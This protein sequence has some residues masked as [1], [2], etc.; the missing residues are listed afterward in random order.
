MD[1]ALK[2]A[3]KQI[4]EEDSHVQPPACECSERMDSINEDPG[5]ALMLD[6][7][8]EQEKQV[9]IQRDQL[10]KDFSDKGYSP[11][12][13]GEPSEISEG[14]YEFEKRLYNLDVS[15]ASGVLKI[16]IP[17]LLPHRK[18]TSAAFFE[19]FR[20]LLRKYLDG[21]TEQYRALQSETINGAVLIVRH[22]YHAARLVKDNDNFELR[23]VINILNDLG[24][25]Y[26]DSGDYLSIFLTA[27]IE[28]VDYTELCLMSKDKFTKVVTNNVA[29]EEKHLYGSE[30]QQTE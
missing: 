3:L 14:L 24:Y 13:L 10:I 27:G 28:G 19:P 7:I 29:S 8:H 4:K 21:H 15:Y 11:F 9:V 17:A 23:T 16:H 6:L 18:Y 30:E 5:L 12:D 2:E 1:K 22:A 25:I 20:V 26:T